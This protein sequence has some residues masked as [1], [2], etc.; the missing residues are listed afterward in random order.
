MQLVTGGNSNNPGTS[1]WI[2]GMGQQ[3]GNSFSGGSST[4]GEGSNN[5]IDQCIA[6]GLAGL[7][8]DCSFSQCF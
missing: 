1:N 3:S 8:T 4:I 7:L 6:F 2:N 5:K